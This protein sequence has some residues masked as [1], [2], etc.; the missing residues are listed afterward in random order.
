[1]YSSCQRHLPTPIHARPQHQQ[2]ETVHSCFYALS[3]DERFVFAKPSAF[4]G[5]G[6]EGA[7]AA[8]DKE[9]VAQIQVNYF[10]STF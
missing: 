4:G 5:A 6:T 9:A 2:H 10:A 1:M 8:D 7:P 3:V